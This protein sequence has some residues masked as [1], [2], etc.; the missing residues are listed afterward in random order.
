MNLGKS[1]RI[2]LVFWKKQQNIKNGKMYLVDFSKKI[3]D[4]AEESSKKRRN[5]N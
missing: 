4:L 3:L 1:F 2:G 5:S